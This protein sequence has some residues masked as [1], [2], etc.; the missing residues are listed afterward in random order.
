VP[1]IE[2]IEKKIKYLETELESLDNNGVNEKSLR[3][4]SE[5]RNTNPEQWEIYVRYDNSSSSLEI[6]IVYSQ[7]SR[8]GLKVQFIPESTYSAT[9]KK[10]GYVNLGFLSR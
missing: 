2:D 1:E 5:A 6:C 7:K 9:L 10:S 8:R 4:L 3:A